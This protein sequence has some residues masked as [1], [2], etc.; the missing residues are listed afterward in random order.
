MNYLAHIFLS[1]SPQEQ[2]G[3]FIGD[4]V[5][6]WKYENFPEE[7][8]KGILRHRAIDEFTDNHPIVQQARALLRPTFGRYAGVVLDLYFDHFLAVR[9]SE[10]SAMPLR[11]FACRFYWALWRNRRIL[12]ERVK[13]F[14]WHFIFTNRLHRYASFSGLHQSFS[15]M[16]RYK[17]LPV[18]P[19]ETIQFLQKN[20]DE[21][22]NLFQQ[23]FPE[24]IAF[25]A[26][27][28]KKL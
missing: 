16:A 26:T 28:L 8:K 1:S 24:V 21:L 23:F 20:Y 18:N 17:P 12:P 10:Y 13:G 27:Y 6:G 15:I 5:K 7:I 14:M 11:S 2:V 9:F 25:E 4:F 3:N 22:Q 19:D